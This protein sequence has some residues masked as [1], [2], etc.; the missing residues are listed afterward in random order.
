MVSPVELQ[1]EVRLSLLL[2]YRRI[3]RPAS[4]LRS[5]E[6]IVEASLESLASVA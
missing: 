4:Q 3:N 6:A 2:R 5:S 1:L